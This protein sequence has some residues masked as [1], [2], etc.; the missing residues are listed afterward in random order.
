[1]I[2][3]C[4]G[5]PS[6]VWVP[7]EGGELPRGCFRPATEHWPC[8]CCPRE[9]GFTGMNHPVLL[10]QASQILASFRSSYSPV[11]TPQAPPGDGERK[12]QEEVVTARREFQEIPVNKG[13][14]C[15]P[16]FI[17]MVGTPD[18]GNLR[19][20]IIFRYRIYAHDKNRRFT[21]QSSIP[22]C[23]CVSRSSRVRL[24]ATP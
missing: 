24:F 4:P 14:L 20:S 11:S 3:E 12:N 6:V 19:H 7:E 18:S 22:L 13:S 23:V 8:Q 16:S 21:I 1:M 17:R 15:L 10:P 5:S 2:S 9:V